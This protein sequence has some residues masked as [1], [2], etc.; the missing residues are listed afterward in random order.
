MLAVITIFARSVF[1]VEYR[2][3]LRDGLL[4]EAEADPQIVAAA[5]TGSGA[6]G[7]EDRWSDI[8]L[9][10]GVREGVELA[11]VIAVWTSRLYGEHGAV[12]HLDILAGPWVYRAFFLANTLQV[13]LAFVPV[14]QFR[15]LAPTFRVVFGTAQEAQHLAGPE[16]MRLVEFGCCCVGRGGPF[17]RECAGPFPPVAPNGRD[18]VGE[19]NCNVALHAGDGWDG[20]GGSGADWAGCRWKVAGVVQREHFV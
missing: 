19:R 2:E 7:A 9:A 12:H 16:A 4:L 11:D 13:D 17:N 8:D 20:V 15:A 1:T 6:G 5:I 18:H 14:T 3:T 10:F